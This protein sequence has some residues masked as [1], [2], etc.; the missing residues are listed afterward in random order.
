M[1]A[2]TLQWKGDTALRKQLL[3]LAAEAPTEF[4]ATLYAEGLDIM[5]KS[6]RLVSVGDSG[7]LMASGE[8][9]PPTIGPAGVEVRLTYG[10]AAQAYAVIQ[11]ERLDYRHAEGRQA[12]YLEQPV[13]AAKR[14]LAKRM[15][16][17]LV[18]MIEKGR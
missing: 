15:F 3:T 13:L 8:V 2:I 18:Q 10:G 5:A 12:K 7:V 9:H 1:D 17:R 11:H 16:V 14:T 6:K 4:A